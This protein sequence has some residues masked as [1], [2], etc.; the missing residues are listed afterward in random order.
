MTDEHGS[1]V[2][3]DHD[4]CNAA[5]AAILGKTY[6]VILKGYPDEDTALKSLRAHEIDMVA[7]VSDDFTHNAGPGVRL[8]HPILFDW[9]A[10]MVPRTARIKRGSQ[11]AGKKICFLA[12]TE[13]EVNVRSW[14]NQRH[15]NFVPFPFQ[16]EGEMEAAFVT[17]NCSALFGDATRLAN[18][19]VAINRPSQ[20][21]VILSDLVGL[22]PL[23]SACRSD[24]P[25]FGNIIDWTIEVLLLA[26][27]KGVTKQNLGQALASGDPATM[28]LLD[29]THAL[30]RPLDLDDRWTERV[31]EAVGNYGEIFQRD[32]G[33]DSLLG[34]PRNQNALRI[35]GGLM[36]GLPLK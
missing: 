14:F 10:F 1:R 24:D 16:E 27:E 20:D 28:R 29:R 36:Q 18:T 9:Q 35:H 7:S 12:E 21:Y 3:F 15:L 4:I 19:R 8:S 33:R 13:A 17:G 11:L 32:V 25:E 34:L 30:G 22:D 23:A 26:E 31:I 2:D 5:A 6:R